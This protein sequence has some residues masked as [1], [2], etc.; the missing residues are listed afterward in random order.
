[1]VGGEREKAELAE[2]IEPAAL[3]MSGRER[4]ELL[5]T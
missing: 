5:T 1:M 2:G 4:P 3:G